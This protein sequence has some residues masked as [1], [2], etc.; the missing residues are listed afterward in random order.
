MSTHASS[1]VLFV[2]AFALFAVCVYVFT[3]TRLSPDDHSSANA[4]YAVAA[5]S[6]LLGVLAMV[7]LLAPV[8]TYSLLCLGITSIYAFDLVREERLRTVRVASLAPRGRLDTVPAIWI[9]IAIASTLMLVP[10]FLL[11]EEVVAAS[12]VTACAI[13]M[14]TIAYR[15]LGAPMLLCGG[16]AA[17]ERL[18]DRARRS[19]RV[20]LTCVVA[21]GTVFVFIS[22]VNGRLA[23]VTPAQQ[24]LNIA[25]PALWA[26][27][28]MWQSLRVRRLDAGAS[29]GCA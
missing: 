23:F 7:R 15:I 13:A 6:L 11:G 18:R 19:T 14:A 25:A 21:I 29:A 27:L 1:P 8:V 2:F 3:A 28:W 24:A 17:A 9:G 12:I 20:G 16:D 4:R 10:Y 22:F 5:F 26:A